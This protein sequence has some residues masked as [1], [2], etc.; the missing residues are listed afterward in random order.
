MI[1]GKTFLVSEYFLKS[2]RTASIMFGASLRKVT[3]WRNFTP[4]D[5]HCGI[6]ASMWTG[7][8]P[9]LL[10]FSSKFTFSP[11]ILKSVGTIWAVYVVAAVDADTVVAV[12]AVVA[13]WIDEH[14]LSICWRILTVFYGA[15]VMFRL[16]ERSEFC[17]RIC[18]CMPTTDGLQ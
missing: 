16:F 9:I 15:V 5:W 13:P 10:G 14:R 18:L 11:T 7:A 12:V 4:L 2:S 3:W 17:D 8:F 6:I 1:Y